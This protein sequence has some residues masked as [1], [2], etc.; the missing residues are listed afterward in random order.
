MSLLY[1]FFYFSIFDNQYNI[2]FSQ[3]FPVI[4][5]CLVLLF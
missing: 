2:T 1:R 3:K 4:F 5:E